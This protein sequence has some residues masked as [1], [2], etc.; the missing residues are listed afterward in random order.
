MTAWSRALNTQHILGAV[1]LDSQHTSFAL[2]IKVVFGIFNSSKLA[3]NLP[4]PCMAV[5]IDT[6]LITV[7]IVITAV[8]NKD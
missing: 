6:D 2:S 3:A 5:E 8:L 1:L 7:I 4:I